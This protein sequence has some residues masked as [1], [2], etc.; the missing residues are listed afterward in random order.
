MTDA[1]PSKANE[2]TVR[3][4]II[5]KMQDVTVCISQ[6]LDD[7]DEDWKFEC[8]VLSSESGEI[9]IYS[10][11]QHCVMSDG[12]TKRRVIQATTTD[13][14]SRIANLV[15]GATALHKPS[16]REQVKTN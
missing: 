2:S 5:R 12:Y 7:T 16:L 11:T 14:T 8:A 3:D 1:N 9:R 13:N 4:E 15:V 10:L 6:V